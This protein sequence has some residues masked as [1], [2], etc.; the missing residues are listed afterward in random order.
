MEDK[1]YIG[2][3]VDE[4]GHRPKKIIG[5]IKRVESV[6]SHNSLGCLY[7]LFFRENSEN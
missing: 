5:Q 6:P 2:L 7:S 4:E 3:L 1:T